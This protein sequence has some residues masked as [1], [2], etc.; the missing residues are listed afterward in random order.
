M[1]PPVSQTLP[2]ISQK[3]AKWRRSSQVVWMPA[4]S[5]WNG[6][7]VANSAGLLPIMPIYEPVS[8]AVYHITKFK[9]YSD[10]D[11][12][13]EINALNSDDWRGFGP[14]QSWI[15]EIHTDGPEDT[16]VLGEMVHYVIRC[17]DRPDG[18]KPLV[19][20]VGYAFK[21]GTDIK[22]FTTVDGQ[23]YIGNMDATGAEGTD[24]LV[25]TAETKKVIPF[26]SING[27]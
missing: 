24:L 26:A 4:F 27:L 23:P 5:C 2:N 20:D 7:P 10:A 9:A 14:Y 11:Y 17:I 12:A 13:A 19:P 22:S 21:A 1:P 8:I 16:G 3:P 15:S 18:W 25:L 6:D